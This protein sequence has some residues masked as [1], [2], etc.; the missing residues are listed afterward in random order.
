LHAHAPALL[1]RSPLLLLPL[2]LLPLLELEPK[3]LAKKASPLLEERHEPRKGA[4]P[5]SLST[6]QEPPPDTTAFKGSASESSL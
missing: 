6:W 5:Q 2:L 1:L 3:L 4:P